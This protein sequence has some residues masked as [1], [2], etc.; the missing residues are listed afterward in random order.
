M[1][2]ALAK[3]GRTIWRD[4]PN[5]GYKEAL[6]VTVKDGRELFKCHAGCSQADLLAALRGHALAMRRER[7]A[8]E[9]DTAS[10]RAFI[11]KLWRESFPAKGSLA[12][13][14]LRAR[15]IEI[16]PPSLRFL[17]RHLHKPTEQHFP[18]LIAAAMD[19]HG[20]VCAAHR[21]F[22]SPDGKGK[23]NVSPSKMTV[24]PVGGLS[25]HFAEAGEELAISEGIETGLSVQAAT[26]IPTWAALSAGGIRNLILPPLPLASNVIIAADADPVGLRSAH[27]AALV[28]REQGRTVRVALPPEGLDFNDVLMKGAAA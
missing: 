22:L 11:E 1:L 3:I 28:W 8:P 6:A 2:D 14:Y 5:C 23:A 4:C 12:E 18:V 25:C 10:V 17:P 15:G 26:G 9:K 20:K 19:Y 7:S 24:G 27:D 13:T 16:L 21:T